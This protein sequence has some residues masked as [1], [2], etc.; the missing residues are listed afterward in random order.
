MSPN[1]ED[2]VLFHF[3]SQGNAIINSEA[4]DTI[5]T[6][7]GEAFSLSRGV[8]LGI[9][10]QSQITVSKPFFV[11]LELPFSINFGESV[12][13]TPLVFFFGLRAS[14]I[15]RVGKHQFKI[16]VLSCTLLFD[17]STNNPQSTYGAGT[18]IFS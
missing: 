5:T 12:T 6:W 11:S 17:R 15:V 7:F 10:R 14:T 16:L 4:P 3:S 2:K 9:S 13:I 1:F 8:G 18:Q